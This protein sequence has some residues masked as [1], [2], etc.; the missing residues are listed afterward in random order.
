MLA[1][2]GVTTEVI[3]QAQGRDVCVPSN[4]FG[5]LLWVARSHGWRPEKGLSVRPAGQWD[6]EIMGPSLADYMDG[7]VSEPDAE[8]LRKALKHILASVDGQMSSSTYLAMLLLL[9]V[10]N[11]GSFV[12]HPA[13][14]VLGRRSEHRTPAH[15]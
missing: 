12:V 1:S 6:T 10:A 8:A 14:E 3:I 4:T 2:R 5:K 7:I 9:R 13:T 15:A 11:H